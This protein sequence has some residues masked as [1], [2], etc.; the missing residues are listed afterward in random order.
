VQQIGSQAFNAINANANANLAGFGTRNPS[1]DIYVAVPVNVMVGNRVLT[2]V[3]A[4]TS[5][6][7]TALA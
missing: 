6:R 2:E 4:H 7:Q 3:V 1:D 5:A